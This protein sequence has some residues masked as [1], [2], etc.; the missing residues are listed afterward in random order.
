MSRL[1]E[2]S[3]CLI[4]ASLQFKL[5]VNKIHCERKIFISNTDLLK[6]ANKMVV[7]RYEDKPQILTTLGSSTASQ[8]VSLLFL[9]WQI[10][11]L[12]G[13]DFNLMILEDLRI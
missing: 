4:I 2:E 7:G 8:G 6:G 5:K 1:L 3:L 13:N 11:R 9:H 12:F 10:K